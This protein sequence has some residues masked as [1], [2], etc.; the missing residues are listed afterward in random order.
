[1]FSFNLGMKMAA[2]GQQDQEKPRMLML[3]AFPAGMADEQQMRQQ[4]N[5][6]LQQQG[7]EQ[8]FR[9][10]DFE[11]R[12]YTIRG[13]E[14]QVRIAKAEA[15]NGTEVRQVTAVFQ[16]KEG[17]AMLMLLMPEED[18]AD[19]GEAEFEQMLESMK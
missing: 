8:N 11:T 7:R 3:M 15:E 1:M 14:C 9:E 16:G 12:T 19:G 10:I 18:W 13:Q 5:Q 2:F 17:P 4:M 6:S